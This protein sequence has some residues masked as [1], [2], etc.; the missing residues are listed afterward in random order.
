M[1]ISATKPISRLLY[2]SRVCDKGILD[3]SIVDPKH[4][5]SA[6]SYRNKQSGIT[7]CL[8]CVEGQ[9]IQILEGSPAEVESTFE[10]ICRDLRHVDVR[11]VDLVSTFERTFDGWSMACLDDQIGSDCTEDASALAEIKMLAGLNASQAIAKMRETLG[12]SKAA[13]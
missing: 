6:A 7:G 12:A 11:L 10:R 5:A 13:V 3:P 9:F 4:I 1:S 2:T 8:V